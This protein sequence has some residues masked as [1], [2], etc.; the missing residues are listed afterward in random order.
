MFLRF[1]AIP[2]WC[3]STPV[4]RKNR[5][6]KNHIQAIWHTT[7][8]NCDT[9]KNTISLSPNTYYMEYS[10]RMEYSQ[11][12]WRLLLRLEVDDMREEID[13]KLEIETIESIVLSRSIA[14]KLRI[15]MWVYECAMYIAHEGPGMWQ[16]SSC[17]GNSIIV[18]IDQRLW[19]L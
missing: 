15:L 18:G 5:I 4:N 13:S 17:I 6:S 11:I 19:L 10:H 12:G 7:L 16:L 8:L 3:M 9:I 1:L 14:F 2:V